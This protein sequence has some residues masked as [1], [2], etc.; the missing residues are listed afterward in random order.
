MNGKRLLGRGAVLAAILVGTLHACGGDH[1]SANEASTGD[2][3]SDPA[4]KS[5]LTAGFTGDFGYRLPEQASVLG[6]GADGQG[7]IAIGA[8][9]LVRGATVRVFD[10]SGIEIGRAETDDTGL[11]TYRPPDGSLAAIGVELQG[12]DQAEIFDPVLD[13][14]VAFPATTVWRALVPV[15]SGNIGLGPLSEAWVSRYFDRPSVAAG[16]RKPASVAEAPIVVGRRTKLGELIRARRIDVDDLN[17]AASSLTREVARLARYAEVLG[18]ALDRRVERPAE[19]HNGLWSA[20]TGDRSTMVDALR[21]ATVSGGRRGYQAGGDLPVDGGIDVARF[22][23]LLAGFEVPPIAGTEQT[24][25]DPVAPVSPLITSSWLL[26]SDL[27]EDDALDCAEAGGP[28]LVY[29]HPSMQCFGVASFPRIAAV[30]G[31]LELA[32]ATGVSG[33]ALSNADMVYAGALYLLEQDLAGS[34]LATRVERD[35]SLADP[36]PLA[37][38]A[39]IRNLNL[40][41]VLL[42]LL[43]SEKPTP[44]R[45]RLYFVGSPD[46]ATA[47]LAG[48]AR[49]LQNGFAGFD[50]LPLLPAPSHGR[51]LL[52]AQAQGGQFAFLLGDGSLTLGGEIDGLRSRLAAN[53]GEFLRINE[54]VLPGQVASFQAPAVIGDFAWIDDDAMW[55]LDAQRNCLHDTRDGSCRAMPDVGRRWQLTRDLDGGVWAYAGEMLYVIGSSAVADAALGPGR[56]GSAWT[57]VPLPQASSSAQPRI[58][59]L[60]LTDRFV[61]AVVDLAPGDGRPAGGTQVVQIGEDVSAEGPIRVIHE[62]QTYL[63]AQVPVPLPHLLIM[64]E[65]I[66]EP[67]LDDTQ[68]DSFGIGITAVD[69]ELG[70]DRQVRIANFP[71]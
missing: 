49:S 20:P 29:G 69:D 63:V 53:A 27:A 24:T 9:F 65:L 15:V 51:P 43:D 34:V 32:Q 55:L 3:G 2:V 17:L 30:L 8:R 66:H 61:Y 38:G 33:F 64:A 1:D 7:G 35:S 57:A 19:L 23:E 39:E 62:S 60:H 54:R 16:N 5:G 52:A 37:H 36:V 50:L 41:G 14:W 71:Y 11:V 59:A 45:H 40:M 31:R 26:R 58:D 21:R 18:F 46:P 28:L 22:Y 25:R 56:D 48:P 67:N 42:S 10:E 6:V 44:L 13:R 68:R 70:I 4:S 12:N 47:T